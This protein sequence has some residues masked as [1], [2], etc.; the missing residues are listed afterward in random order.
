M[1]YGQHLIDNFPHVTDGRN[2]DNNIRNIIGLLSFYHENVVKMLVHPLTGLQTIHT[3]LPGPNVI[4]A[5]LD[6]LSQP[7]IKAA[8]LAA[9][10]ADPMV[11]LHSGGAPMPESRLIEYLAKYRLDRDAWHGIWGEPPGRDGCKVPQRLL[12]GQD[13]SRQALQAGWDAIWDAKQAARQAAA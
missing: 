5:E 1:K 2:P 13:W 3:F 6:R 9:L 7:I 4:K 10:A 8:E 11:D 12:D